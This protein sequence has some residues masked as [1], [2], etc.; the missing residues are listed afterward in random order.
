MKEIN[1]LLDN[2]KNILLLAPTGWGKTTL[3]IDLIKA[4]N[5]TWIYLAPLRALA[6][7]FYFRIVP[8]IPTTKLIKHHY[9]VKELIQNGTKPKLLIIT[10]E[11]LVE[12]LLNSYEEGTNIVFD[13]IHLFYYWGESF[14][15]TLFECLESILSYPFP[16]LFLTATLSD[17]LR[18]K[19]E[20]QMKLSLN[21]SFLINIKNHT[22]KKDPKKIVYTPRIFRKDVLDHLLSFETKYSKLIFLPYKKEV[23]SFKLKLQSLGFSVIS[24]IGGETE[25][26]SLELLQTPK[27]DFILGT[28]AISHGVNLPRISLVFTSYSLNNYDFWVQMIGRAGRM[29]ENFEVYS[30]DHFRQTK[31]NYIKSVLYLLF[32]KLKNKLL[33]YELRRYLNSQNTLQRSRYN[34]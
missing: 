10:P 4:S 2:S 9:E 11:L 12:E 14:R 30:M 28:S 5:H 16:C 25:A 23:L 22:L 20:E 1:T 34:R 32:V 7:E 27:P 26:F 19:W 31:I 21:E 15:P 24:C 33:P 17:T 3:L 8:T 18:E 29:G 6:N 13:E